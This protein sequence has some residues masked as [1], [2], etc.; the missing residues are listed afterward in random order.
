MMLAHAREDT[1]VNRPAGLYEF[2]RTVVRGVSPD[3]VEDT[4]ARTLAKETLPT[5]V[6]P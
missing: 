1:Q 3:P 6:I 5:C 2:S 4:A